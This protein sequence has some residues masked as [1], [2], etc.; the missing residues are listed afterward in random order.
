[1]LMRALAGILFLVFAGAANAQTDASLEG[2]WAGS[3]DYTAPLQGELTIRRDRNA[4][5]ATLGEARAGFAADGRTLQFAFPGNA[6]AFR[7]RIAAG[8]RAIEGFWLQPAAATEE[9]PSLGG[10]RQPFATPI[11][12]RRA[13]GGVYRGEVH[14][15]P[16]RFSLYLRIFHNEDGILVGAFRNP[17]RNEIGGASR[18]RVTQQADGIRFHVSYDENEPEISYDAT[19]LRDPDRLRLFWTGAGAE[20][21]LTRVTPEQIPDAFPRGPT[22]GTYQYIPPQATSDGWRTARARDVGLDEA[23]IARAVQRIIGSDPFERRPSLIHS[24]LIARRGRLVV[25]EYFFG[26]GAAAPHDTRSAGKTFSS[27]M[28]GAAMR[29]GVNVGPDTRVYELLADMGPFANDDPRKRQITLAHLMTHTTGLACDDNAEN[30]VSPGN[31]DLMQSQRAQPD[32][33]KFTL[34][35]PMAHEP[36][37][38]YAYC[39]GNMNLMG[40]ALTTATRTWLPEYFDR[41]VARPLQFGR[42]YWNLMPTGEGYLGGGAFLR[43]RDLLKIGQLYLDGGVWRGRR[44]VDADWVARSTRPYVE[45]TPETTGLSEEEFGNYY[46]RGADGLA[47]HSWNVNVGD[48]RYEGYSASGNGGQILVVLPELD[49]AVVFTGGNYRQG[50]IWTRWPQ[51]LVADEILTALSNAD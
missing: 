16:Q 21:V 11:T 25:E 22:P 19:L 48:R 42:Y 35:L 3:L 49:M 1:M 51:E 7:G 36:G 38:R 10:A 23:A 12:L 8:G 13:A 6:G 40:A 26:H 14:P 28:L 20:V 9:N 4:W 43:P 46:G 2:Y 30:P 15:L 41:T 33:W 18:F 50:G 32:W 44:I 34:D 5:Q 27:V 17:E 37:A 24:M 39:S 45:I 31:E 47:W 29:S